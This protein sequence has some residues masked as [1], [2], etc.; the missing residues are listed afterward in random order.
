MA[1]ALTPSAVLALPLRGEKPGSKKNIRQYLRKMLLAAWGGEFS[2][3]Y[4]MT[5][6]SD[7]QYDLYIPMIEAGAIPGLTWE[8]DG[9]GL[10]SEHE[11]TLDEMIFR[12]IRKLCAG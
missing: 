1:D 8:D 7:W 12:A 2:Y 3:K 9:Y 6:E 10:S 4:G 11:S 5:G